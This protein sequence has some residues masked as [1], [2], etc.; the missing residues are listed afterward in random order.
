MHRNYNIE[1]F[2][3]VVNLSIAGGT[4]NLDIDSIANPA[5][6]RFSPGKRNIQVVCNEVILLESVGLG[7]DE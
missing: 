7:G 6:M 4:Q 1:A 3:Q 2:S 5:K